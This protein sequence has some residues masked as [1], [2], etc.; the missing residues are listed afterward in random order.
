MSW[1][2]ENCDCY[3]LTT[4]YCNSIQYSAVTILYYDCAY[5]YYSI[6]QHLHTLLCAVIILLCTGLGDF[7]G[8]PVDHEGVTTPTTEKDFDVPCI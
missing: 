1:T 8:T 2:V 7:V 6:P 4:L 3:T 5:C